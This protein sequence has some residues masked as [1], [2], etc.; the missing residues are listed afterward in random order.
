MNDRQSLGR[1]TTVD[2]VA[3]FGNR[4]PSEV[5]AQHVTP[6]VLDASAVIA[7]LLYR[8]PPGEAERPSALIRATEIGSA[9]LHAKLDAVDEIVRRI[10][11]V[12]A[13]EARNEARMLQLLS[14]EYVP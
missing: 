5:R 6:V 7:D 3:A 12:A 10:P 4:D 1:V 11:A 8:L 2:A 13:R 14:T 9:R